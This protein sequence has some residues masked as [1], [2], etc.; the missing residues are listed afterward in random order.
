MA[1]GA[2]Q[3]LVDKYATTIKVGNSGLNAKPL[4]WPLIGAVRIREP[5]AIHA[6]IVDEK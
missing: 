1:H 2:V 3:E 4:Y 5:L 6:R